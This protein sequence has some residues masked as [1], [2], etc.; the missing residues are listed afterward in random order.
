MEYNKKYIK[1]IDKISKALGLP[2]IRDFISW[3]EGN[4]D[5]ENYL[6]ELGYTEVYSVTRKNDYLFIPYLFIPNPDHITV[7]ISD[8]SK[9][10]EIYNNAILKIENV[11]IDELLNISDEELELLIR[12]N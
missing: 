3:F 5:I 9:N 6:F 2:L 4:E 7:K 11:D 1:L 8:T 10:Y 12:L